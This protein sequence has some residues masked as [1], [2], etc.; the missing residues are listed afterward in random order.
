[1]NQVAKLEDSPQD[2]AVDSQ[3]SNMLAQI[4]EASRNPEVNAEKME[5]MA[6]L[7][8]RLQDR[9]LQ[10]E[11]NRDLN[12]AILEMPVIT[13][14]GQ[15]KIPG[16]NG[17]PDRVQGTF[18]RFEDLNRV[19]KPILARHNLTI[20]FK[21]RSD[22]LKPECAP[23]LRHTNGHVDQGEFLA[24]PVDSSGSKN[25]TQGVGSTTSY[26]KRY[27]MCAALNV[28]TEGEDND[29]SGGMVVLPNERQNVVIE[30]AEAASKAGNYQE[31]YS[32]QSPKDRAFL[33]QTGKHS[34]LGGAALPSPKGEIPTGAVP[35]PAPE[36]E[37]EPDEGDGKAKRWAEKYIAS[38]KGVQSLDSLTILR[39]ENAKALEKIQVEF[40]RLHLKIANAHS[41]ATER[42]G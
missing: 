1:M 39:D 31:W 8:I 37:P 33:V 6:N 2:I 26:L 42:F 14:T 28:I 4:I 19:V 22:D 16:K 11:F 38:V 15:I 29:G 40:P 21:L 23:V 3:S 41:E 10:Q 5:A 32:K 9:E 34:E 24:A 12:A 36:P 30:E 17:A 7:A 20:T 35:P 18:A 25:N 13:K 27:T